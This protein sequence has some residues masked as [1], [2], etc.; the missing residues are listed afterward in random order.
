MKKES[1]YY[2]ISCFEWSTTGS[3]IQHMDKNSSDWEEIKG[4]ITEYAIKYPNA[5]FVINPMIIQH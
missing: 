2:N 5:K 4:L 1:M 3:L